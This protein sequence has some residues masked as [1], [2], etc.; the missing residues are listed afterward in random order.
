M[1]FSAGTMT[2]FLVF[3]SLLLQVQASLPEVLFNWALIIMLMVVMFSNS[4][5]MTPVPWILCGEW[6][7]FQHKVSSSQDYNIPHIFLFRP[8]LVL[9]VPSCSTPLCSLLLS[10]PV[11]FSKLSAS[12]A[13]F[14]YSVLFLQSSSALSW[15]SYQKQRGKVFVNILKVKQ[16]LMK[17]QQISQRQKIKAW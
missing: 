8:Q 13:C 6:P 16:L 4:I 17:N 15:Y 2:V 14:L 7:D 12:P 5:G 10:Y 9:R 1:I 11:F 3:I